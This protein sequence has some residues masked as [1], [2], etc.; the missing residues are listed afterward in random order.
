MAPR[1]LQPLDSPVYRKVEGETALKPVS[2]RCADLG[3]FPDVMGT[4]PTVCLYCGEPT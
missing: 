1:D 4:D 2:G 3:C